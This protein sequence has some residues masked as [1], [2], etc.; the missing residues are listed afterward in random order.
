MSDR[1]SRVFERAP[2][3]DIDDSSK[4]ILFS[5][6]HRGSGD[7]NDNFASNENIYFT[8]MLRYFDEGYTYIELGDGD[9][10][11]E[12]RKFGLITDENNH[13]FWL[14]S[15]FHRENRLHMIHGNHDMVKRSANWR[16]KNLYGYYNERERRHLP[17]FGD[18]SVSEGLILRYRGADGERQLRLLHGHQGDPLCDRYWRLGRFLVRNVW[19]PLELIGVKDPRST[20]EN[21]RKR[22]TIE[23]RLSAWAN[24]SGELLI[25]GHTHR[26]QLSADSL[27]AN[28]GSCV[29]PRCITGIEISGGA[30]SLI[31]WGVET[32]S[33]GVL[34]IGRTV[35]EQPVKLS[36]IGER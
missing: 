31:K 16:R 11:W 35:L 36:R 6:C 24:R 8:A 25:A 26:P 22:N 1:I 30:A 19:R 12:N 32:R 5:D 21:R 29:H 33:D 10:L 20:S 28:T 23:R 13:I 3:L 34:F 14:L 4:L 7:N 15:E 18:M 27:Y 9:E 17:L 2:A